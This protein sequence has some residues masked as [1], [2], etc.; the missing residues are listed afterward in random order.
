M[1]LLLQECEL[2]SV[3][4]STTSLTAHGRLGKRDF[5]GFSFVHCNISGTGNAYLSRAWKESSRV[6][7]SYTYMGALVNPKGWDDKGFVDRHKYIYIYICCLLLSISI[8]TH[9][10][11]I[12][13]LYIQKKVIN[14]KKSVLVNHFSFLN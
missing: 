4:T 9:A 5:S 10:F 14:K 1:L 3:A 13:Y 6:V 2:H 11:Y 8:S 12:F 7:F